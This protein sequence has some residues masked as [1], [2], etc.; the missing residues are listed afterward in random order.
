MDG[1]G[2][3]ENT[4]FGSPLGRA[5]NLDPITPLYE[6]NPDVLNSTVFTNFPVVRDENGVL[7]SPIM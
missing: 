4:E 2:I 7:E 3:A 6:T 1:Q 5:V